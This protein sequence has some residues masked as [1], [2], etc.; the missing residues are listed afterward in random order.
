MSRIYGK[1]IISTSLDGFFDPYSFTSNDRNAE[2]GGQFDTPLQFSVGSNL[3]K[4]MNYDV[5][6]F[7]KNNSVLV[8]RA[9][10]LTPGSIGVN[11]SPA[12]PAASINLVAYDNY[13]SG[14]HLSLVLPLFNEWCDVNVKFESFEDIT[15]NYYDFKI[16]VGSKLF[17]DDY[18]V[19]SAYVGQ[20]LNT[21]L[22]LDVDTAGL[23]NGQEII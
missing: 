21:I 15:E 3:Y 9:R 1:Y 8:K 17:V 20:P 10:L 12:K 18:N 5:V 13:A 19:Q 22:E 14:K 6:T 7:I 11:P 2:V 4:G 16:K 23:Y